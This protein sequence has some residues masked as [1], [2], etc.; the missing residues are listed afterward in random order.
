MENKMT[1]KTLEKMA[2]A[3]GNYWEALVKIADDESLD[4]DYVV[5]YAIDAAKTITGMTTF[6]NFNPTED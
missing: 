4:R 5:H 1:P 2:E 6:Q 3:L